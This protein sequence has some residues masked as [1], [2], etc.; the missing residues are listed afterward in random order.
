MAAGTQRMA[1]V[2][3]NSAYVPPL[4]NPVNDAALL[5]ER[6][7]KLGFIVV[8]G[9]G[10]HGGEGE[11]LDRGHML[12]LIDDFLRR[13][14]PGAVVVIYYAGHG[15]QF[16][17][18]NYLLPVEAALDTGDPLAS[19]VP[20]RPIVE[21][22][23]D[24]AGAE[25][26]VLAFLD[27]CRN[28]PFSSRQMRDIA[29][30]IVARSIRLDTREPEFT[31][32]T[33]GGLASLKIPPRRSSARSFIA[34]A[35]APGDVA[36]DGESG[37]NS[38]FALAIARHL[39]VRG[40]AVEDF[41]DRVARDVQEAADRMGH[42]QEP[43]R[44][45]NLDWPFKLTPASNRPVWEL[46]ALGVV[47]G[48]LTCLLLFDAGGGLV[49]P[50]AHK[51][52]WLLG[53]P[54]AMVAAAGAKRW[55]SGSTEHAMLAA[56]GSMLG[57][58]LAIGLLQHPAIHDYEPPHAASQMSRIALFFQRAD[59]LGVTLMAL[60]AGLVYGV[61]NALACKPQGSSFRG[62]GAIMGGIGAGLAVGVCY[63]A[64]LLALPLGLPHKTQM[65][66]LGAAWFGLLGLHLGWCY[67]SYV[68]EYLPEHRRPSRRRAP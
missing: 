44:E 60:L 65:V 22:A 2:I 6:L 11:N 27:A 5:T 38:P 43:W 26:T 8:G 29:D 4:R 41:Y 15:L 66:A 42:M 39:G 40:L 56:L 48:L 47:A 21:D 25:G 30:R 50:F 32:L 37:G 20:L 31:T 23:A 35:T 67:A 12:W 61:L 63:I 64:Y 68:P 33:R 14:A 36:Y 46:A 28:N 19:L 57:F 52:V 24:R 9:A 18:V 1:L 58:A 55:G 49:D 10:R 59:L 3:G 16:A 54:F 34:F 17:D 7:V 13:I 62:F 51:G 53:L 45:T